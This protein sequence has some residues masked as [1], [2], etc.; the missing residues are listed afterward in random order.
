VELHNAIH[1]HHYHHRK[2]V[3]VSIDTTGF[4][5]IMN[6]SEEWEHLDMNSQ[7]KYRKRLTS[8][9]QEKRAREHGTYLSIQQSHPHPSR[10]PTFMIHNQAKRAMIHDQRTE[11]Q[12][13]EGEEQESKRAV[14]LDVLGAARVCWVLSGCCRRWLWLVHATLLG[15]DMDSR[16]AKLFGELTRMMIQRQ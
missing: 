16:L 11:R 2:S 4:N 5:G 13:R 6:G 8:R 7:S 9:R 1:S 12:R 10:S 14:D 3:G 15:R